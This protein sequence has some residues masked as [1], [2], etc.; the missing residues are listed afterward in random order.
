MS[1][2][3]ST[4][5]FTTLRIWNEELFRYADFVVMERG[6]DARERMLR[7]HAPPLVI[8]VNTRCDSSRPMKPPP[9]NWRWCCRTECE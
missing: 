6:H 1:D 8:A 4:A 7:E 2:T 3:G 9:L 5:T